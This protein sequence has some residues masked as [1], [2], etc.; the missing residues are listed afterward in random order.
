MPELPEVESA[1]QVIERAGLERTIADVDDSDTFECRPH[2]PGDLRKALVGRR[3]TAAHRRGKTMWCDTSGDGPALGIHL[4]MSGRIVVS[5]PA[6]GAGEVV[7]GG[8]YGGDSR[9]ES[10]DDGSWAPWND[11]VVSRNP[12]KPEWYRFTLVYADGGQLRLFDKRRL[13]RVRLDPDVDALGPDAEQIGRE[14]FRERIGRG[15]APLKA[16]LLDQSAIAGIGN[17]LADEVLWRARLSPRHLSGT[18]REEELDELRRELRASIR[19]AVRHGGVHTGEVVPHRKPGGHC[20][21]CGA[22]MVH[23]TVGGR[24]TWWCPAEQV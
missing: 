2:A 12:V 1:R 17:L 18:L 19:H 16:R 20:P 13:G 11:R 24:S 14:E 15:S 4:G 21:R 7:V 3:L 8:D 22:E 9:D 6:D 10:G 5:P 23:A